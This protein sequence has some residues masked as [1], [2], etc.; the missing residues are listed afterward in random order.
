MQYAEYLR[1][2]LSDMTDALQ[3]GAT[4]AREL[5]EFALRRIAEADQNG[6]RYNAITWL[7]AD[8]ALAAATESDA[9]RR[10]G[11]APRRLEGIPLLIKDNIAVQGWP[12]SAGSVLLRHVIAEQDAPLVTALRAEGAVLLGKTAMHELAAGITGASS[13]S[14]FTDNAWLAG[15]SPGGSSSGSAVAVAAGYVPLAIGTDTAGSVRIPA[16]FNHLYGLR[17]THGAIS[18]DGIV[19]LSPSQDIPGALVR[20]PA[21]LRLVSEILSGQTLPPPEE[22]LRIGVWQEGFAP[23]EAAINQA[24]YTA[25]TALV[26]ETGNQQTIAFPQLETLAAEASI[27]PWEFAEAL[28]EWLADKPQAESR[29]L[30]EVVASGRHHPQLEAVFTARANHPGKASDSYA[31]Q[32]LRQRTL[33]QTLVQ[34]FNQRKIN[35]LAYPVVKHPP[36]RH[37]EL[38]PGSNALVAAVTGAPAISIPVGFTAQGLPIGMELLALRGREDLLLQAAEQMAAIGR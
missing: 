34:L 28:A 37:G 18:I 5:T 13:L 27:I 29:T 10:R 32:Q 24:V 2:S 20:H 16:A 15:H 7:F 25:V 21:D 35:L 19:P 8:Q 6:P 36:V 17:M 38:Q 23:E 3:Q 4:T 22:P 14:G 1:A 31:I 26:G 33:Y 12:T 11:E 9:R 30:A